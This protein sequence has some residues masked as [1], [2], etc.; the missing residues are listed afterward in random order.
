MKTQ[1]KS[2]ALISII[3]IIL[4]LFGLLMFGI[5]QNQKELARLE[6]EKYHEVDDIKIV[7]IEGNIVII[8]SNSSG[9]K[10]FKKSYE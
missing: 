1:I 7:D 5:I 4:F 3:G 8:K 9:V 10:I 6:H 2:L